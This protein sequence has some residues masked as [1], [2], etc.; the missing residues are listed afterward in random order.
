MLEQVSGR[1]GR[2]YK[3]GRV[4]VQTSQV[5]HPILQYLKAHNYRGFYEHELDERR[6]FCYP[7]FTKVINVYLKH[8]DEA[9]LIEASR[10]YADKLKVLFGNRVFGPEE[11]YVS[12]VQSLYIR[13]IMLKVEIGASMR[14]VKDILRSVFEDFV[15][16]DVRMKALIVYYDV[17]PM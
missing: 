6:R 1:A 3:Q 9:I 10:Q 13:K 12:R 11:P 14:K 7:P 17:D 5:D 8:R 16:H 4:I 15:S 2:R